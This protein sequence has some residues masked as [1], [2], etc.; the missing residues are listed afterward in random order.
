MGI[1]DKLD[2]DR[3]TELLDLTNDEDG[4][5]NHK[6]KLAFV[7]ACHSEKIGEIFLNAGVPIVI[8]VNS[9]QRI[10]DKVCK[11][12]C[13]TFYD[14]LLMGHSFNRAYKNAT[15]VVKGGADDVSCCCCAHKHKDD[16]WW[17]L[18][19]LEHPKEAHELHS[20]TCGCKERKNGM[21]LHS[22]HCRVF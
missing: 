7:S 20:K 5:P 12:F 3:L 6:V 4:K 15:N 1:E 17:Y 8:A 10:L 2:Q 18:Y 16:C 21:V 22:N 11:N 19:S 13:R 14:S 9:T